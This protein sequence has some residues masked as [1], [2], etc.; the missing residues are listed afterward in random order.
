MAKI[1]S[2]FNQKGGV[3]KTTTVINLSSYLNHFDKKVLIVDMDPQGNATSGIGIEDKN[4]LDHTIYEALVDNTEVD[5]CII[6]TEY[7]NLY[8]LPSNI[9]LAG[10]EVEISRMINRDYLLKD[11]LDLVKSSFD[12]ILIDCPPALSVLTINALAASDGV[13]IPIQTEYY[14]LEGVSELINTCKLVQK[15]INTDL[16][17]DGVLITMK[18]K[19]TNLSS[20]VEEN[21][22]EYF[23]DK[24]Y[25]TV[26][27]RNIRL[28]EAPS[29][30][31]PI[32]DH[33]PN[34]KGAKAYLSL[35][36]EVLGG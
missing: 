27:P 28:A 16:V 19:R 25:D 20:E 14:A 13:I 34:S 30:G 22:R 35:A 29:F 21:V 12:Y 2:V 7:E 33:S 32:L 10:A 31:V 1:L 6:E 17:I 36:K 11:I 9:N 26:I 4:N 23:K 5:N 3:G 24:V 18:D 15:R 8:I